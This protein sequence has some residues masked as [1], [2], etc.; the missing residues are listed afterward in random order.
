[1]LLAVLVA[2]PLVHA[3]SL[4][5]VETETISDSDNGYFNK[6]KVFGL[7]DDGQLVRFRVSVPHVMKSIGYVSG[8]QY[9][10]TALVC[11]DFRV[12]DG[13]LYGVGNGSGVYTI[14]T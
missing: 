5:E 1:V 9:S 3:D 11:I 2:V 10:D 4:G 8:L 13:Q 6:L 14:N 7:T 12:Q